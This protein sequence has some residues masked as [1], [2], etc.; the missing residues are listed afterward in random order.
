MKLTGAI[1]CLN[2]DEVFEFDKARN[3]L[4]PVCSSGY[5]IPLNSFV[6][7]VET[8]TVV[9]VDTEVKLEEKIALRRN[10]TQ[11]TCP[12]EF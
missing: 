12:L 9:K 4:C 6:K 7:S 8:D 2:C 1:L 5:C 10:C 11:D 3:Y